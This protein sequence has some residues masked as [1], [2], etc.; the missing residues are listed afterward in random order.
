MTDKLKSDDVKQN[1]RICTG[2]MNPKQSNNPPPPPPPKKKKKK[3][4]SLR[5]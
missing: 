1:V 3:N 4:G 5:K 2:Q